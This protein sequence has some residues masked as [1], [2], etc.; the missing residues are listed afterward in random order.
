M[1][2]NGCCWSEDDEVFLRPLHRTLELAGYE[3]LPV[4]SAE[5]GA[6]RAQ[7]RRT[8]TWS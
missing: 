6:R 3:V 1:K 5:D 4:P 2:R 8:W 7:G